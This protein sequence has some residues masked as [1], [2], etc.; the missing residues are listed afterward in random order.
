MP[1]NFLLINHERFSCYAIA[2]FQYPD[3]D[4]RGIPRESPEIGIRICGL[5]NSLQSR[6]RLQDILSK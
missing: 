1:R 6:E 3:Y 5:V 2:K 4:N